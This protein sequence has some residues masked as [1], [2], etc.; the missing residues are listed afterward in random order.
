M[1]RLLSFVLL[2]LSLDVLSEQI[3]N[4]TSIK[5]NLV[6]LHD[7]YSAVGQCQKDLSQ[8]FVASVAGTIDF[9]SSSQGSVVRAGDIIL[10]IDQKIGEAELATALKSVDVAQQNY[11]RA[12]ELVKKGFITSQDLEQAEVNLAVTK[13]TLATAK[14]DHDNRIITAPFSGDIGVIK[15]KVGDQVKIGDTLFDLI[16]TG[17]ISIYADLP[18]SLINEIKINTFV[19]IK[20]SNTQNIVQGKVSEV[21]KYINN[22][23]TTRVKII[24]DQPEQLIHGEYVSLDFIYNEHK[25]LAVPEAATLQNDQGSFIYLIGDDKKIKKVFVKLGTRTNDNIEII[26]SEIKEDQNVVLDG[27]TKVKDGQKVNVVKNSE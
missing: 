2:F 24:T 15:A 12:T 14:Q 11:D 1:S 23:G 13:N 17:P 8:N 22:D 19:N 27:L 25:G 3:I 6:N 5:V 7:S 21:S 20:S 9:V 16:N 26:N 10:T 4:I 18:G